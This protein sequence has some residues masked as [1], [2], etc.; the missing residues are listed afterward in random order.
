[1]RKRRTKRY[2]KHLVGNNI[3]RLRANM[4]SK[5]KQGGM[6]QAEFAIEFSKYINLKEGKYYGVPLISAWESGRNLPPERRLDQL[7]GFFNVSMYELCGNALDEEDK[8][9]QEIKENAYIIPSKKLCEFDGKP[10]Y[11]HSRDMLFSDRW[12][13]LDLPHNR[14]VFSLYDSIDV[15]CLKEAIKKYTF[16]CSGPYSPT[17]IRYRSDGSLT[18]TQVLKLRQVYV[19]MYSLDPYVKGRYDGW[20]NI[21]ES[22]TCLINTRGDVLPLEGLNRSYSCYSESR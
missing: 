12:G 5:L 15:S 3:K 6:T 14:I 18:L 8:P 20:F 21:N 7:C 13:I 10:V 22:E 2:D 19:C 1:M 4:P 17:N 9:N 16:F 11:V